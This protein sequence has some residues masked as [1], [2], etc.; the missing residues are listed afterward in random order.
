MTNP[1]PAHSTSE[2][3]ICAG[4]RE[5][6][7]G[8][9][10]V[11]GLG[12]PQVAAGLAA[13]THA[14]GLR[15]LNEIGVADPRPVEFGVGN[16]DPRHWYRAQAFSS[17]VGIMGMVL[18]RGLVDIGFLGALEVDPYG[19]ANATEVPV[20]GGGTRRFGGGG[21]ANDVASLAKRTIIIVRHEPRK[22]VE[23]VRHV[24][25][26]GFLSGGRS[27]EEAGLRGGGPL[28]VLTDKCVF[29]FEETTRRLRLVSIHPGVT[30]GELRAATGFEL[31]IPAGIPRTPAP[32]ERELQLIRNVVDPGRRYTTAF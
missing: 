9:L 3:M 23:Q 32:T 27:R 17:F 30:D 4:A 11:V 5:L 19:N 18:H 15:V 1:G 28:R 31:K 16:A 14:P 22:L 29:G 10:A 8:M 25:N 26:P 13:L 12:I 6:R 24:T 21:G 7:D 2:L 20:E